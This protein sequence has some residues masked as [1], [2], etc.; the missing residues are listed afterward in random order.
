MRQAAIS[1]AQSNREQ[2]AE[3]DM[4]QITLFDKSV[5]LAHRNHQ[6]VGYGISG[7]I[8]QS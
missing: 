2:Q 4:N 6:G 3:I 8:L 5:L 1:M 7:E